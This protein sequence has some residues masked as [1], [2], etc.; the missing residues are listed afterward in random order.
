[1]PTNVNVTFINGIGK[2]TVA[3]NRAGNTIASTD[4]ITTGQATFQDVRTDDSITVTGTCAGTVKI[5]I[6][7]PTMPVTPAEYPV[8][9]INATF[10]V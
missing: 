1:M 2:V 6:T 10:L 8:G 7:T 4:L 3:Q 9:P 5:E